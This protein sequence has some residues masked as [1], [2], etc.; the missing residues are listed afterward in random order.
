M[1]KE[2]LEAVAT[3]FSVTGAGLLALNIEYSKWGWI[4][5]LFSNAFWYA[6]AKKIKAPKLQF[7]QIVFSITSLTGL[8]RTFLL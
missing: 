6:Y 1:K 5:F 8:I 3:V 4:L 2:Q 7:T